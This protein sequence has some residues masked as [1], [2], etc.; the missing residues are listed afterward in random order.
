MDQKRK[1]KMRKKDEKHNQIF[2]CE[3][4]QCLSLAFQISFSFF[5][6]SVIS[7]YFHFDGTCFV[8]VNEWYKWSI[9]KYIMKEKENRGRDVEVMAKNW[10][11]MN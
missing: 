7:S 2:Y 10:I 8:I 11:H 6:R 1:R 5:C 4:N 9:Y 3:I